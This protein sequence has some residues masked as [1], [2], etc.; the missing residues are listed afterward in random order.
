MS[1]SERT[2]SKPKKAAWRSPSRGAPGVATALVRLGKR[3]RALRCER[4]LTQEEAAHRAT[5]D[6]KHLQAIES[7][8]INVTFASLVGI[9]R[10]LGVAVAALFETV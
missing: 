2:A 1:G 7:G 4:G 3:I 10:S 6:A 5:L 8:R 9:A